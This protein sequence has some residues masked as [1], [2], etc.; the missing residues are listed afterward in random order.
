MFEY[1]SKHDQIIVTGPHRSGTTFT[2]EIIAEDLG[3][4]LAPENQFSGGKYPSRYFQLMYDRLS[5]WKK[6][7]I[8]IVLHNPNIVS[9][10]HLLDCFTPAIVFMRRNV[11][12]IISSERRIKWEGQEKRL[13]K[14]YYRDQGI[15]SE[16]IY[17]VWDKY[18]KPLITHAYDLDYE[19]LAA[20]PRWVPQDLRSNFSPHQTRPTT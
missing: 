12:D 19:S 13:I 11:Q 15:L 14:D 16:V 18:Q 17:E 3:Y 4:K 20:H 7:G 5:G 2:S 8:K 10:V 1:L 9:F 6:Q